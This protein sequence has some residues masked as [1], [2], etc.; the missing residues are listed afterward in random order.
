MAQS[1]IRYLLPMFLK[2]SHW[3]W[4]NTYGHLFL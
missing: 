4:N 2:Q 3:Q 1:V